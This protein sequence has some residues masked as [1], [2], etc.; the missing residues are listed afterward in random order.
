M[1][2]PVKEFKERSEVDAPVQD[3]WKVM[4][5]LQKATNRTCRWQKTPSRP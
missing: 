2:A 4:K 1:S 5:G 3:Y